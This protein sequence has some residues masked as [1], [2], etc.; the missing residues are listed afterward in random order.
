MPTCLLGVVVRE[1]E[2]LIRGVGVEV[3]ELDTET[4]VELDTE[5]TVELDTETTVEL[6]TETTVELDTEAMVELE[7]LLKGVALELAEVDEDSMAFASAMETF[8]FGLAK[9]VTQTLTW[10]L[11]CVQLSYS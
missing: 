2:T 10:F 7:T 6:D 4:M 5:T 8:A 11:F 9:L 3:V 1:L